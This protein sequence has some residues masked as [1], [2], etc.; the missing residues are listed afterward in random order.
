[1]D[2]NAK[3]ALLKLA[4][5]RIGHDY[6]AAGLRVPTALLQAWIEG[7]AVMPDRKFLALADFLD[8]LSDASP[9][10]LRTL[11]TPDSSEAL[12]PR[13]LE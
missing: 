2:S 4:A 12:Q 9:S 6:L 10:T 13:E 8:R 3:R 1:M 11:A 7:H 5:A